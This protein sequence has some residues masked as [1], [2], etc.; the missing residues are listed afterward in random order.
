[1]R[2]LRGLIRIKEYIMERKEYIKDT[3]ERFITSDYNQRIDQCT[4]GIEIETQ[5]IGVARRDAWEIVFNNLDRDDY[6]SMEDYNEDLRSAVYDYLND[7]KVSD[8]I[9]FIT[10]NNPL[11]LNPYYRWTYAQSY[12]QDKRLTKHHFNFYMRDLIKNQIKSE[13]LAIEKRAERL[14][15]DIYNE[16]FK[17]SLIN[18]YSE[19]FHCKINDLSEFDYSISD[20]NVEDYVRDSIDDSDYYYPISE[21]VRDNPRLFRAEIDNEHDDVEVVSDQSVSGVELRTMGGL[22]QDAFKGSIESILES[23]EDSEHY[24]DKDCSA[25]MH[26]KLGDIKHY[27]G[28]GK[29]HGAIMEYLAFSFDRLPVPVQDRL[30]CGGNR[31]IKPNCHDSKYTWVR[32]HP[33]GTIEFRL[34]GNLSEL[35]DIL[36]CQ[37][38][39]LEALAYGYQVRFGDYERALSDS[40]VTGVLGAA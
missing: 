19:Y 26:I 20:Y 32:F 38:I 31:W 5:S 34:F 28:N 16:D 12:Y 39:A 8:L 27:Y 24:I 9:R 10:I 33:Q 37:K 30:K 40:E 2:M 14:G 36:T 6:M 3:I 7:N 22:G 17:V 29:L 18:K 25:H 4:F 35:E 23:I 1:M 11:K 15:I 13:V 21:I